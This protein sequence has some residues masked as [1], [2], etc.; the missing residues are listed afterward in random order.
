MMNGKVLG[1]SERGGSGSGG[2]GGDIGEGGLL[3]VAE[4]EKLAFSKAEVLAHL[5]E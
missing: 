5:V 3:E 2:G 4:T 1:A